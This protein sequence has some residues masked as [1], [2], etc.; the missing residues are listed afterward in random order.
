MQELKLAFSRTGRRRARI[1]CLGAHCDD[2]D[3]GC[4]GTL[5]RLLAECRVDVTWVAFSGSPQRAREL[6]ASATSFLRRAASSQ[7]I[8]HSFDDTY[9]PAQYAAIKDVFRSL[10]S[11]PAPDLI[12]THHRDDLHQDHR[13]VAELTWNA[14]R[15]HLILEY[16]IPKYEGGLVTPNAYV[17]LSAAEVKRK[18]EILMRCYRSQ[19][20]KAWFTPDT[21]RATLR[22][23]GIESG[24]PQGWA[25]GFHA[26]KVL[27]G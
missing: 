10:Q 13:V 17:A 21:F 23:R 4:G 24:A 20:A 2:I 11:L 9:F 6:R 14:F 27:L 25:E 8:T 3:I 26:A 19:G 18:V 7:I 1:L 22:L 15:S 16:E 12:F 5:L